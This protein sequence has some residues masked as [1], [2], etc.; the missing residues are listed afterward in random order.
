MRSQIYSRTLSRPE[1]S[2]YD[3]E[4]DRLRYDGTDPSVD[5][6]QPLGILDAYLCCAAQQSWGHKIQ[7]SQAKPD[8][9][10]KHS[11]SETQIRELLH[12]TRSMRRPLGNKRLH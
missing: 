6:L 2:S 11:N 12:E 8:Q 5:E 4:F 1:S 10:H 9:T 7:K 3:V